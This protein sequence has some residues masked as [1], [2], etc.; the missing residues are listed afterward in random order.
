MANKNKLTTNDFSN[1]AS[2]LRYEQR[3]SEEPELRQQCEEGDQCGGCSFFAPLNADF[4]LCCHSKARHFS[5]TV[6]E[7]FTCP[8]Y[9]N[10]GWGAHSFTATGDLHCKCQGQDIYEILQTIVTLLDR[11]DLGPET[12]AALQNLR[13]KLN[14]Y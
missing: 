1:P 12:L 6:F 11:Q 8:S 3:W 10:E 7:H 2:R 14:S 9:V 5:E 13:G 4:G